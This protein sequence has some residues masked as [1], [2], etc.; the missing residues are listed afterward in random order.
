[1][2]EEKSKGK[3]ANLTAA[4]E[5]ATPPRRRELFAV[6]YYV[7]TFILLPTICLWIAV[8]VL[9]FTRFWFLML[10]YAGWLYYDWD[11]P[12]K[13]SRPWKMY[14]SRTLYKL[15]AQYFPATLVK[16]ADLEKNRNYLLIYHPHGVLSVAAFLNFA[17]NA[18]GFDQKFPGMTS[19][20][21]TLKGQFTIPFRREALTFM[22][23]ISASAKSIS[24]VLKQPKGGNVVCLVVGG[25]EEAL[26]AHSNCFNLYLRNRKGFV[27]VALQNGA[28]LIPCFSFGENEIF[29]QVA[30][31]KGTRLRELQTK[32]KQWMGF[33]PVIFHGRGLFNKW[34]GLVPYRRRLMTV[35]GSPINLDQIDDPTQEQIDKV[36]SE[37]IEKL[38]ALFEEHKKDYGVSEDQHLCIN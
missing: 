33:S 34:F 38:N 13:G 16:T 18:T 15:M 32:F 4:E 17:T 19:F 8:Y 6:G 2:T 26:D 20:L 11:T 10:F 12:E 24:Y 28:S 22:G 9:F 5:L 25:A 14:K 1:M 7:A 35:V 3:A 27:R 30:N 37:Y 23:I 21:V 36:H 29:N 31:E